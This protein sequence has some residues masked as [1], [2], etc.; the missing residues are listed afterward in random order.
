MERRWQSCFNGMQK[1]YIVNETKGL[2]EKLSEYLHWLHSSLHLWSSFGDEFPY[3]FILS[4]LAS[5]ELK[6]KQKLKQTEN[7]KINI[8]V[9]VKSQ[10]KTNTKKII[11]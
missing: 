8:K 2:K 9:K 6:Q 4:S 11:R 1:K 7:I 10:A 5:L 3:F